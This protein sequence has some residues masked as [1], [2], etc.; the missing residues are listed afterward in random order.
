MA[1]HMSYIENKK[2]GNL[3]L[4]NIFKGQGR[5][6]NMD[7]CNS[8]QQKYI[9]SLYYEIELDNLQNENRINSGILDVFPKQL[10]EI[11]AQEIDFSIFYKEH[12]DQIMFFFQ[13]I[14]ELNN[15]SIYVKSTRIIN[16]SDSYLIQKGFS[17]DDIEFIEKF[18]CYENRLLQVNHFEELV[19]I[20]KLSTRE[21]VFFN[22]YTEDT[23]IQGNFDLSF[24]VYCRSEQSKKLL[25]EYASEVNLY[26]RC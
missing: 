6:F 19:R 25:N 8:E 23:A 7:V 10:T 12:E 13:K 24:P 18:L 16:T 17:K 11:E 26:I 14:F 1:Q 5:R 4:L 15:S 21:V 2:S 9:S 22:F 3:E 20:I